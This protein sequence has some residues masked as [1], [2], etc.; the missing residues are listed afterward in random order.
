MA[1]VSMTNSFLTFLAFLFVLFASVLPAQ[2]Q[3]CTVQPELIFRF[4][5]STVG[6]YNVWDTIYGE[7]DQ[8]ERFITGLIDGGRTIILGERQKAEN[9]P[10]RLV[11]V[12][13]DRRGRV[14]WEKE[15]AIQGLLSVLKILPTK[16][17]YLVLGNKIQGA[18]GSIWIGFFAK[19]GVLR[20]QKMIS[21]DVSNL[22]AHDIAKS[23]DGSHYVVSAAYQ[24]LS[25]EG[26]SVGLPTH[27]KVYKV[28]LQGNVLEQS[29]YLPSSENRI[30]SIK[31]IGDD[32]YIA[33]GYL[34]GLDGRQTGWVIR[35]N[36]R[37]GINW[38]RQYPRGSK[39]ELSV[40]HDF[41]SNHII[42][43][44]TAYP[45]KSI[46]GQNAGWL[47]AINSGNGE[48]AWQRY[49]VG[50]IHYTVKDVHSTKD[51][52]ISVLVDGDPSEQSGDNFV[53][54]LT[55]N[56]RGTLLIGDEYFNAEGTDA[57]RMLLGPAG[58]RILI[59]STNMKYTI[60]GLDQ[61]EDEIKRSRDGWVIAGASADPYDDPCVGR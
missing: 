15:H 4:K 55:V 50:D 44:G 37:L 12:G 56:P 6:S 21:E 34:T 52:L 57:E 46:G 13:L 1:N 42:V 54:V 16:A 2:A 28:S 40:F 47:M 35:L 8:Q 11:L 58:E 61:H 27:A 53:R 48:V 14:I 24:K 22:T 32:H 33:T 9:D 10:V 38:Q 51:G 23:A 25:R 7:Q 36:E 29:A 31:P 3:N 43:G 49:Y 39:A 59:G 41:V 45:L 60:E 19:D 26:F 20:G 18:Q 30:L 5:K 17:G